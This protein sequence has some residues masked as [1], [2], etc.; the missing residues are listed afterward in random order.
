MKGGKGE[1]WLA[2]SRPQPGGEAAAEGMPRAGG[3]DIGIRVRQ[4]GR[5]CCRTTSEALRRHPNHIST[6]SLWQT[7][8]G[9]IDR[10]CPLSMS[11]RT[12]SHLL[13]SG[14]RCCQIASEAFRRRRRRCWAEAGGAG[15]RSAIR[16][17]YGGMGRNVW[18][19]NWAREGQ[20]DVRQRQ[21]GQG[22]DDT[23]R[24]G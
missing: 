11:C 16:T 19:V 4:G 14:R 22:Q 21:E 5:R 18:G 9:A 15:P 6:N 17:R 12:L 24:D 1:W 10:V 20:G 13:N 2:P 3:F 23:G 7:L 8:T